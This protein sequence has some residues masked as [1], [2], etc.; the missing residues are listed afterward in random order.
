MGKAE[1]NRF[2]LCER[3]I[4]HWKRRFTALKPSIS[5]WST[6]AAET[7]CRLSQKNNNN[8]PTEKFLRINSSELI[9]ANISLLIVFPQN[10]IQI[11]TFIRFIFISTGWRQ[12]VY[13]SILNKSHSFIHHY[14][15]WYG[16]KC[17]EIFYLEETEREIK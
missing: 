7:P 5:I 9:S 15:F 2:T 10:L 17:Y 1:G 16:G 6:H 11:T 3:K 12:K 4:R 13:W 14:W 8:I